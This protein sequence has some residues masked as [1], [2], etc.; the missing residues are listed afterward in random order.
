M[1]SPDGQLLD[2]SDFGASLKSQLSDCSVVVETSHGSEGMGWEILGVVLA[3]HSIGVGWI[4]D[5]NSLLVTFSVIVYGFAYIDE[6]LSV[7]F[8]QVSTLHSWSTWL[9][10]NQEVV[11][12]I[13]HGNSERACADNFI[14]TWVGTVVELSLDTLEDLLLEWQV[15]QVKNDSLVLAKEFTSK[16]N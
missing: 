7:I 12:N 11:A 2:V 1:V 5:D 9:C 16:S 8:Q 13:L 6:D 4:S 14:Q 15:E 10:T 3:D